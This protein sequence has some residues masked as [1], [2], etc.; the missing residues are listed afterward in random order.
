[1]AAAIP[2]TRLARRRPALVTAVD[3]RGPGDA[4]ARRLVELGFVPG[5][6]VEVVAVVPVGAEPMLVQV[7]FTRFA[8]RRIEADRVQVQAL[9]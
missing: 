8:L 7:G 5:E 3:A 2:L 1:M 9:A 6:Q 4:V